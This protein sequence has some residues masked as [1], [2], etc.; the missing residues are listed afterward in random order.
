MHICAI[1]MKYTKYNFQVYPFSIT[2]EIDNGISE[3]LT[4][5]IYKE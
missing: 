3:L 2:V 1:M 5:G 4:Q